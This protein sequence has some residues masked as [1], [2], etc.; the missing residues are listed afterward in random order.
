MLSTIIGN[1]VPFGPTIIGEILLPMVDDGS[2]NGTDLESFPFFG[3]TEETIY[4][5]KK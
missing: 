2:S 3:V 5:S 1:F 4:V